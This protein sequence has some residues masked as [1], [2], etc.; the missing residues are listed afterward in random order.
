M[1]KHIFNIL[2]GSSFALSGGIIASGVYV[3]A[4]R[5]A[6]IDEVKAQVTEYATAAITEQLPELL[7]GALPGLEE[8][9]PAEVPGGDVP[10][11]LPAF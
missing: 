7:D 11:T 9:V 5:E 10:T 8:G 6:I 1:V 3:Y 4:N 2:A